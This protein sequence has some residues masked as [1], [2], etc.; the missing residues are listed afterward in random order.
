MVSTVDSG[1]ERSH[2]WLFLAAEDNH[3]WSQCTVTGR[4]F[5]VRALGLLI[6]CGVDAGDVEL[7][8]ITQP[9]LIISHLHY[10][11]W[12]RRLGCSDLPRDYIII[13]CSSILTPRYLKHHYLQWRQFLQNWFLLVES[14]PELSQVYIWSIRHKTRILWWSFHL[15]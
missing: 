5:G 4:V 13:K 6:R 9:Q 15:N 2:L 10:W 12:P 14:F 1:A 8:R 3:L 7:Y 11:Q